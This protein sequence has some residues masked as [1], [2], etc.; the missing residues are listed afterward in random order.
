MLHGTKIEHVSLNIQ[1]LF[2][3]ICLLKE[4]YVSEMSKTIH[5]EF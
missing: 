4:N 3:I 2:C 5:K 1:D